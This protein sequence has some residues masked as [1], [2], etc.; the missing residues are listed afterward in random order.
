MKNNLKKKSIFS[1]A[2][3]VVVLLLGTV[4]YGQ[5][6][7]VKKLEKDAKKQA[8]AYVKQGWL[9]APGHNSIEIQQLRATKLQNTFNEDYTPKYIMGSAM[10]N[11]GN[12]DAAK[13]Q[14][15][16]LAKIQIAG[17]ISSDVAGLV[18]NNIGNSQLDEG[19]A[20]SIVKSIGNYKSF[21]ASKLTNIIP[22][23]DMYKIDPETKNTTVT[24]GLFYNKEEAV[25]MGIQA[26]REQM[27][28]ES[29]EL[30]KELD[31]LLGL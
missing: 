26:I 31:S 2:V 6:I 19:Q 9:V 15:T 1:I 29:E 3:S 5:D 21:V 11:G 25:K 27:M 22:V 10:S 24:V 30:G 8:K 7:S 16:E 28:K 18:Q 4:L 20:A 23:I 17:I 14:A 12:Y 13:F